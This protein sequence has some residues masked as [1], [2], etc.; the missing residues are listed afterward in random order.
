MGEYIE[1]GEGEEREVGEGD[2]V[3]DGESGEVEGM[4]ELGEEDDFTAENEVREGEE[5]VQE[6]E[7][8]VSLENDRET[9][10]SMS[11]PSSNKQVKYMSI[12]RLS[13]L[14]DA[15]LICILSFLSTKKAARASI[16]SKRWQHLWTNLPKL[17]FKEKSCELEKILK[18]VNRIHGALGIRRESYLER[19]YID[20]HYYESFA[21]DVDSWVEYVVKHKV[22]D[23][24]LELNPQGVLYKLPQSM[25]S[26]SCFTYLSLRGCNLVPQRNVDWKYLTVLSLND[27][28]LDEH[29][30]EKI[31]SGC[32]VMHFLILCQ[33]WGLSCL[34]IDSPCVSELVLIDREDGESEPLLEISAPHVQTLSISICPINKWRLTNISSVTHAAISL[35]G[36]DDWDADDYEVMS[37]LED[38]VGALLH[39][40]YLLFSHM[41][42]EV[43]SMLV[44]MHDVQ[45]PE[46]RREILHVHASA[47]ANVMSGIVALLESSPM[48]QE[49]AISGIDLDGPPITWDVVGRSEMHGN[50]VHLKTVNIMDFVAVP[51][52]TGE[53]LLTLVQILLDK[54]TVLEKLE[55]HIEYPVSLFK[56]FP[57]IFIEIS[58][59]LLSY[60][61]SSRKA[62]VLLS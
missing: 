27:V 24:T 33:C 39:V 52:L 18:T 5:F 30:I 2:E 50:L 7:E 49:L 62:V 15:L 31:L 45:L 10:S 36:S 56:T 40:K 60:P 23:V 1:L 34:K 19:L 11:V 44:E 59:K 14:P 4:K 26:S 9:M 17:R 48:L 16:L 29:V 13:A 38:L 57:Q 35:I 22:K 28:K 58:Q 46:S 20:F 53:P 47:D 41:C 32:P 43:L 8:S 12:D 61:R 51:A 54:A 3:R 25:Y 6:N 21:L 37:N 42:I 55:I